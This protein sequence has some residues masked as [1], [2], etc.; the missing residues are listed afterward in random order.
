MKEDSEARAEIRA[1][2]VRT[3]RLG[4]G[5]N[6]SSLG[7]VIDTLFATAVFGTALFAGVMAALSKEPLKIVPHDAD[8][9]EA[10]PRGGPST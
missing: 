10:D 1:E 3:V 6:C 4:H 2:S 5:A 7:S 8:P 9:G